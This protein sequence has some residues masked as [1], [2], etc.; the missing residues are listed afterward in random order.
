MKLKLPHL[1]NNID[2][3]VWS[4]L[5]EF[6]IIPQHILNGLFRTVKISNGPMSDFSKKKSSKSVSSK[7]I[8]LKTIFGVIKNKLINKKISKFEK[9]LFNICQ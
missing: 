1:P 9:L 8:D 4:Y 5:K 6:I 2:I 7:S 3:I